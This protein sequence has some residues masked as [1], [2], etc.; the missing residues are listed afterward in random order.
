[1]KLTDG[2]ARPARAGAG[3]PDVRQAA[4]L[5]REPEDP[6]PGG[7][8]PR[9]GPGREEECPAQAPRG[10]RSHAHKGKAMPARGVP[11][12]TQE[13][14]AGGQ[15]APQGKG[16][17]PTPPTTVNSRAATPKPRRASGP[18]RRR[19]PG[20]PEASGRKRLRS[21]TPR[22]K[23]PRVN[24]S[25]GPRARPGAS[26]A[27]S[28]PPRRGAAP[29]GAAGAAA[30]NSSRS[31]APPT[32]ELGTRRIADPPKGSP[33]A[34]AAVAPRTTAGEPAP[35]GRR[36]PVPY[37]AVRVPARIVAA[38]VVV[39][40]AVAAIAMG[41]GRAAPSPAGP[42]ATVRR[43]P[44]R[45]AGGNPDPTA[46]RR[47]A[48]KGRRAFR[49]RGKRTAGTRTAAIRRALAGLAG[50][51][52]VGLG[53]ALTGVAK[54][55][56][57]A[58]AAEEGAQAQRLGSVSKLDTPSPRRRSSG[59]TRGAEMTEQPRGSTPRS[60]TSKNA[61][62]VVAAAT[63][64][65]QPTKEPEG[66]AQ[67]RPSSPLHPGPTGRPNGSSELPGMAENGALFPSPKT[68]VSL[69]ETNPLCTG[70]AKK[71]GSDGSLEAW[72]SWG[73]RTRAGWNP[74]V[75]TLWGVRQEATQPKERR[76]LPPYRRARGGL[77]GWSWATPSPRTEPYVVACLPRAWTRRDPGRRRKEREPDQGRGD[78]A[79]P[80]GGT[81]VF[82]GVHAPAT[83][84]LRV[85]GSGK[86]RTLG[87]P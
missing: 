48:A 54:V 13:E 28:R 49:I 69:G 21:R 4:A 32:G 87:P 80:D 55:R 60:K 86:P 53:I 12:K 84:G 31:Y 3:P 62:R 85:V 43:T 72:R 61:E 77:Q 65:A 52:K 57:R 5:A 78:R 39:A 47:R 36:G 81:Y 7:A 25:S 8:Q 42:A 79:C 11:A 10:H 37:D 15:E 16:S 20:S 75:P 6:R 66:R 19:S 76:A 27:R 74:P 45:R 71:S 59:S 33:H 34:A 70:V 38:A 64:P 40:A 29:A 51:V 83:T 82:H 9:K 56:A 41:A 68:R 58:K 2:H 63:G 17:P 30:L 50:R 1:M 73:A 46:H 35:G 23:S 24:G 26:H 14:V 44:C 18:P 67:G 22:D